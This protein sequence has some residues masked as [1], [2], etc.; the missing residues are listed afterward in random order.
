[1]MNIGYVS[2][3]V[4]PFAKTGGLA[5]VAGSL[6]RE[7]ANLGHD[8]KVFMP[9][10]SSISE[11]EY[12]LALVKHW[13]VI[14]IKVGD[15]IQNTAVYKSSLPESEV[16]IY[17]LDCP[18]YF[19]R[20]SFYTNDP[21]ED[22]RF[23]LFS[24][25]V[26]EIIQRLQ[27][28]PDII[29]C[30]DWQTGVIPIYL[31]NNYSWD[32]LFKNTRSVFTI[33]NIG[34]QGLF[35]KETLDIADINADFIKD[36]EKVE[37]N[38]FFNFLKA[39]ISF[40]DM[41]N[42]VS[43]TYANELLTPELGFGM[44]EILEYRGLDFTGILN[45]V[46]YNE[47][48]PETDKLIPH[49]YSSKDLSGKEENKKQLLEQFSLPYKKDVP[50][51]GIISRLAIQKGFD[52]IARSL[53]YLSKLPV[54]WVILGSGEEHYE[55]MFKSF[56]EMRPDKAACYIGYNN[57]FAHLIEAGAD[58]FLMPSKY[59]PCGLNQ[60]YSL[61]YGTVPIVRKTGGLA[62]TVKDWNEYLDMGEK[63]GDGFS[64]KEYNGFGLT[65]AVERAIKSY[66]KKD[67][68]NTI[69]KNGMNNDYSW[70]KSAEKYIGLYKKALAKG[71]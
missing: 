1:M 60:I 41:I 35:P 11:E 9:K 31:K 20:E 51:I 37:H 68:W 67:V 7:I 25:G 62:D 56:A 14:P 30:N 42:T 63:S 26:M 33:H 64:F 65:D 3:E 29:H 47:W 27:W 15:K 16:E 13:G 17:F 28:A 4:V 24:K 36:L 71:V 59:E 54:Q 19:D 34:Y 21:D 53:E 8:V 2:S 45:G 12:N 23:I 10:Y 70:S 6:P 39:G 44:E 43:P 48:N 32:K 66:H 55:D 46:D 38:G 52:L 61:K 22:E 18:D 57:E 49:N 40:A 50:V 5:D 69:I 58:M